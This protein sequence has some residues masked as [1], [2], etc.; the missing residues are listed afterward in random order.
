M[1]VDYLMRKSCSSWSRHHVSPPRTTET[2][3]YDTV[4]QRTIDFWLS[5]HS[6]S[7][8]NPF[9]K[10]RSYIQSIV[11]LHL[12]SP[13]T[14]MLAMHYL[15]FGLYHGALCIDVWVLGQMSMCSDALLSRGYPKVQD[16]WISIEYESCRPPS[17]RES[18][19]EILCRSRRT[20]SIVDLVS[21]PHE[22]HAKDLT[23]APSQCICILTIC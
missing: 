9:C 12:S 21:T 17:W 23:N 11:A 20:W 8:I 16:L 3:L 19:T 1:Y 14:N 6:A 10:L 7:E 5:E 2:N 13:T 22:Q 18:D 4:Q 15:W